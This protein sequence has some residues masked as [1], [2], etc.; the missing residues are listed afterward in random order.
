MENPRP[1]PR[2]D[3][4]SDVQRGT[5][6]PRVDAPGYD[7]RG[8]GPLGLVPDLSART[9]VAVFDR[10]D[11]ANASFDVLRNAG[12]SP[13]D[14]SIVRQG[15]DGAPPQAPAQGAGETKAT[16]GTVTGASIGAL[17]GG[18]LGLAALV[19]PGIGPILAIGPIAAALSGAVAGGAVGGLVG[20]FVGLGIPTDEAKDYEAAVRSGAV[21]VAVKVADEGAATQVADLLRQQGA[22]SATSYQPAL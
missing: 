10:F 13:D 6:N 18:A 22:R 11:Q 5:Q 2:G 14:V 3:Q 8:Q 19:I 1:Q 15:E 16:A 12:Y 4:S 9:V 7:D 17:V 20:S 21:I